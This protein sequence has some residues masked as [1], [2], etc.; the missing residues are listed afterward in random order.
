[1][2]HDLTVLAKS[3]YATIFISVVVH[4]LISYV[5]ILLFF[6]HVCLALLEILIRLVQDMLL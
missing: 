1:M 3:S 5:A 2:L 4:P 6:G